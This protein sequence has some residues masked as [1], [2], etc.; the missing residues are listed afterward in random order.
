MTLRAKGL[1]FDLDGT[2]IDSLPA[3]DRAWTTF[4][5]RHSLEPDFVLTRIHGRRSIDSIRELLPH[6]DAEAE[7]AYIRHLEST[8]T[9]GVRLLPGS[10]EVLELL[11]LD[12]W[13][14]VT[15]GT[16]DIAR[17]RLAAV[18]LPI[19]RFAVYGEDVERGKPAP[20]PFILGAQRLGFAPEECV[21]FEDTDTG[22][23][24][25]Q[26]SGAKA[27]A[28]GRVPLLDLDGLIVRVVE[29]GVELEIPDEAVR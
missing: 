9:E 19:P 21:G 12:R 27:V 8:D 7:N 13:C 24:S 1:L 25:V 20:D 26:A 6:V 14:L 11:P 4:A 3:V 15:S 16:S 2:L 5:R 17:A 22:L 23:A 28:V 18:G 10:R 29:D